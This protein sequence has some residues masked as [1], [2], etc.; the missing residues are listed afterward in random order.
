M[1]AHYIAVQ[2]MAGAPVSARR[3]MGARPG[4]GTR[5]V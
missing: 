5:V 1:R 3:G 4:A 2:N